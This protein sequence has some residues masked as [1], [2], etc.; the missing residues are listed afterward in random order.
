MTK[1]ELT[2]TQ[3]R[4]LKGV[5]KILI[6]EYNKVRVFKSGTVL[7]SRRICSNKSIREAGFSSVMTAASLFET[8]FPKR[9]CMFKYNNED[10]LHE[11]MK[12][13]VSLR[14]SKKDIFEYYFD[15]LV[16]LKFP[17]LRESP[18]DYVERPF[19]LP[20]DAYELFGEEVVTIHIR[21]RKSYNFFKNLWNNWYFETMTIVTIVLV[22]ILFQMTK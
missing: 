8:V 14:K 20:E 13:L 3:I 22:F 15:E 2:K 10:F 16:S 19:T 12:D 7:F 18:E 9:L 5:C 17:E 4:H 6:P 1:S 21:R 11:V